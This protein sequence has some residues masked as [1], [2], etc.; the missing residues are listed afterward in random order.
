VTRARR[1][2][3]VGVGTKFIRAFSLFRR[4]NRRQLVTAAFG[5]SVGLSGCSGFRSRGDGVDLTVFNQ[6]DTPFTVEIGFYGDGDSEGA[7][8]AY[9]AALDVEGGG[10]SRREG[11]VESGR[12]L[13]RYQVY[14]ENSRLTDADHVHFIPSGDGTE[15]L[16]FDIRETG[17]LTRR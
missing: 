14:E 6:T 4:M 1:V 17:T 12:Y 15:A 2:S 10:E 16:T 5:V 11:V 8:S 9:D 3:T 13:V 7:A